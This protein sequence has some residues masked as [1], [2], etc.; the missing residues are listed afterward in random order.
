MKKTSVLVLA[1]SLVFSAGSAQ[2]AT[3]ICTSGQ[4][5]S[6]T[7]Q[8]STV[9]NYLRTVAQDQASYNKAQMTLNTANA[10]AT[11]L[12]GKIA[13][14]NAK[15][16]ALQAKVA[17][18]LVSSPSIARGYQSQADSEA[19]N[20]ATLQTNYGWAVR[21]AQSATTKANSAL[22]TLTRS[23]ANLAA[24]QKR[25]ATLTAQCTH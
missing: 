17:K 10:K 8:Q 3:K 11:D 6:I 5:F 15:I 2:A 4:L 7:S 16:S 9:N 25:L 23:Q 18:N 24:Q 14:S 12:A 20:L 13:A 1:A 22:A 21:D 19:R